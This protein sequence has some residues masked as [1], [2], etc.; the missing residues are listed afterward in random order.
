[1]TSE[2]LIK[3]AASVINSRENKNTSIGDVGCALITDKDNVFTGVCIDT[4]S[5]MGFCAEH[6]AIGSMI[7]EKEYVIKKIVAVWKDE[8]DDLYVIPPC[9][10]CREFMCQIDKANL[11]TEVIL[12]KNKTV[13]LKELLPYYDWWQKIT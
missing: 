4:G 13:K 12:D 5:S 11:E 8:E 9:G 1:M 6:N 10:R 7:T 2:D 3:K